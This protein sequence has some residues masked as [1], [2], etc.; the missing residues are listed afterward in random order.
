[1]T[2]R[3]LACSYSLALFAGM[4]ACSPAAMVDTPD[5]ADPGVKPPPPP[6]LGDSLPNR[7][8]L[9]HLQSSDEY[10]VLKH[11]RR[12][13]KD[14]MT[15]ADWERVARKGIIIR[16]HRFILKPYFHLRR[17]TFQRLRETGR[18]L[19]EGSK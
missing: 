15:E 6:E 17:R 13:R 1:M 8:L 18:L 9:A 7:L 3:L 10:H 11:K 2:A 19:P 5:L 12:L 16:L 14:E 4:A